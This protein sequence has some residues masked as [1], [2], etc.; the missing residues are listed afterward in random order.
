MLENGCA[1]FQK[2]HFWFLATVFDCGGTHESTT[3]CGIIRFVLRSMQTGQMVGKLQWGQTERV[4]KRTHTQHGNLL[5]VL[6]KNSFLVTK[7]DW[8]FMICWS[9]TEHSTVVPPPPPPPSFYIFFF[10][11]FA[12][13]TKER[14]KEI[15]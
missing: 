10:S 13:K 3:T 4:R 1:R 11:F 9:I 14:E 2:C 15:G 12:K 7:V 6:F 5:C 8:I